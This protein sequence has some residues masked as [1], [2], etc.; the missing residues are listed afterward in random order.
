MTTLQVVP[1]SGIVGRLGNLPGLSGE[2]KSSD[3][4]ISYTEGVLRFERVDCVCSY[5][6][7]SPTGAGT[8]KCVSY[9][10]QILQLQ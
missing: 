2:W 7:G 8:M 5:Y 6:P 4:H 9:F 1:P 10:S 3:R